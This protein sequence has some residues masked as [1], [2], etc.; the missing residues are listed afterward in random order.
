MSNQPPP[1]EIG[2]V[3]LTCRRCHQPRHVTVTATTRPTATKGTFTI[4]TT[5]D[6][7]RLGHIHLLLGTLPD[8]HTCGTPHSHTALRAV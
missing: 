6:G 7:T 8:H 4:N 2:H 5:L 1:V 3:I